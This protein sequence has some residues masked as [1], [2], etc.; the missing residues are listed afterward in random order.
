MSQLSLGK[1]EIR[2][3]LLEGI[4]ENA[5]DVLSRNGYTNIESLGYALDDAALIE[6]ISDAHFVGI[7]SRTHI[8]KKSRRRQPS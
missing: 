8:S 7:R 5:L 4:H 2:F 1:H 3:V 6:K